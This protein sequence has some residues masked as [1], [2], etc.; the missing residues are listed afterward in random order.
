M[1]LNQN[2]VVA[3]AITPSRKDCAEAVEALQVAIEVL[4][5]EASRI[6]DSEDINGQTDEGRHRIQLL[7]LSRSRIQ[8]I[9]NAF[10]IGADRRSV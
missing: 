6:A 8:S 10:A 4:E 3:V 1:L 9:S 7:S 5:Y 2:G